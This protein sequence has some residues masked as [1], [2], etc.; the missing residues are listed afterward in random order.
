MLGN[1]LTTA[2]TIYTVLALLAWVPITGFLLVYGFRARWWESW[3]GRAL[4]F[5]KVGLW[6]LLTIAALRWIFG[7]DYFGRDVIRISAMAIVA[8][9]AALMFYALLKEIV[10][11][12]RRVKPQRES[13]DYGFGPNGTL[14]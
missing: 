1:G 11:P 8:V 2:D 14:H 3:V 6:L 12:R 9:G 5:S 4:L 7:L 13:D 10:P